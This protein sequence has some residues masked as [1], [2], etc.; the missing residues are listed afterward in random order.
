MNK[1][2]RLC[3]QFRDDLVAIY[4]VYIKPFSLTFK[5]KPLMTLWQMIVSL[6]VTLTG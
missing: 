3:F 6:I 5:S 2:W 4:L 1:K